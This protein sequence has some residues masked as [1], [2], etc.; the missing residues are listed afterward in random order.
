MPVLFILSGFFFNESYT[1]KNFIGRK[2]KTL[3]IPYFFFFLVFTCLDWNIYLKPAETFS[4]ILCQLINAAGPPKADP[5]WFL[6]RLFE[7][8]LFYFLITFIFKNNFVRCVVI[9]TCSLIGYL[10]YYYSIKP[11]LSFDVVLSSAVFFGIGHLGK[12]YWEKFIFFIKNKS[13]ACKFLIFLF[14]FAISRLADSFNLN[15]TLHF[16]RIN[17]YFLF[18]IANITGGC[19]LL[20]LSLFLFDRFS[21]NTFYNKMFIFFKYLAKNSL[22]ILCFHFFIIIIIS[23]TLKKLHLNNLAFGVILQLC[24]ISILM[25]YLIIPLFNKYF[26]FILGKNKLQANNVNF[27]G[28]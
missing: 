14:L 18:Y 11:P 24:G 5:I 9:L 28:L 17:N 15:H 22:I 20:I 10:F 12:K 23:Q 16:N 19:S 8:N 2:V 3:F 1:F 7:V 4:L 26:Y 6:I 13:W 21:N 25:Y 27:H